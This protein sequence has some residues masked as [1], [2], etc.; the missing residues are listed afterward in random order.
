MNI[1]IKI[2][3]FILFIIGIVPIILKFFALMDEEDTSSSIL[4]RIPSK[5]LIMFGIILFIS[6]ESFVI[7]PTG[8]TGVKTT[9]GQISKRTVPTGFNFK[10]PFVQTIE[11]VNNKQIE[12]SYDGRITSET[13]ERNEVVFKGV[14]VTYQILPEKSAW[15]FA[16]VSDY[17]HMVSEVLVYSA[18]K[19]ASKTLNPVDVTNRSIL[20]PKAEKCIQSSLDSKYGKG[21]ILIN[22]VI[23]N[24]AVFDKAYDQKI[25][26]KQQ[27]Q[28]DYERQQIV[29]KKNIEK[30]E[31][32]AKVKETNA[33][34]DAEATKI[35]AEAEAEANNKISSSITDKIIEEKT[36]EARLK[37]G[38]VTVQGAGNVVTNK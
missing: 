9:F 5:T 32:N 29:N 13:S 26:K 31:T 25:A 14:T 21:V 30:A 4:F 34:A 28:I 16:H 8:Y 27:A 33:K 18:I 10:I 15:I 20:E 3:G 1:L 35:K 19:T 38:W 23:I 2:V 22:K 6:S 11:K 7:L 36:A 17:E 12:V 24:K 37:H